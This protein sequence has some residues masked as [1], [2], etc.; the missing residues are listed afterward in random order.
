M[1]FTNAQETIQDCVMQQYPNRYAAQ[2]AVNM[3]YYETSTL[4]RRCSVGIIS[5]SNQAF[6]FSHILFLGLGWGSVNLSGQCVLQDL[7]VFVRESFFVSG[8]CQRIAY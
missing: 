1:P 8:K 5:C 3:K 4:I 6:F 7:T 2:K